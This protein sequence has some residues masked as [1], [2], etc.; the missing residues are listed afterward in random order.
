V[1]RN[2]NFLKEKLISEESFCKM[3][4]SLFLFPVSIFRV[5]SVHFS[6]LRKDFES[7]NTVRYADLNNIKKNLFENLFP[8]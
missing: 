8:E 5:L 7:T 6:D 2:R 4:L 3:I 1:L